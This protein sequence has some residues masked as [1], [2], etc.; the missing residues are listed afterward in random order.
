MLST[1]RTRSQTPPP[2]PLTLTTHFEIKTGLPDFRNRTGDSL[3]AFL[4]ASLCHSRDT[5]TACFRVLNVETEP[6]DSQSDSNWSRV[7]S[8]LNSQD[9]QETVTISIPPK[10]L[11]PRLKG[12]SIWTDVSRTVAKAASTILENGQKL[13]ILEVDL[14]SYHHYSGPGWVYNMQIQGK[15]A[16]EGETADSEGGSTPTDERG[17]PTLTD[18]N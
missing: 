3:Y 11:L 14:R 18:D 2:K 7:N 16:L 13:H 9:F 15:R 6:A 17:D 12:S 5:V 4:N 10:L 8:Y 1:K